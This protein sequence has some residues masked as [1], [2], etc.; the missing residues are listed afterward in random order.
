VSVSPD[1]PSVVKVTV[2]TYDEGHARG[3]SAWLILAGMVAVLALVA[4]VAVPRLNGSPVK[5]GT[6]AA[7]P[8]TPVYRLAEVYRY[9]LGCL[10]GAGRVGAC[11][12]YG[13][14]VTAILAHVHGTWRIALEAISR[15][16]PRLRLPAAVRA[17]VALCLD[18]DRRRQRVRPDKS[19]EPAAKGLRRLGVQRA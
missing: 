10:G 4:A 11:R 19:L 14:Y 12:H 16:C 15:S 13:V 7:A 3:A 8:Q 1:V 2:V 5:A 6:I 17:H 18:P 9:P